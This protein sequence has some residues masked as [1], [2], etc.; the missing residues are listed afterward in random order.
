MQAA[1]SRPIWKAFGSGSPTEPDGASAPPF[2]PFVPYGHELLLN[3][4]KLEAHS[5]GTDIDGRT[6]FIFLSDFLPLRL[7]WI[8]WNENLLFKPFIFTLDMLLA[9]PFAGFF[10]VNRYTPPVSV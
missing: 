6:L 2:G 1:N 9:L 8:K 3:L 4:S 10:I 5:W 7:Y